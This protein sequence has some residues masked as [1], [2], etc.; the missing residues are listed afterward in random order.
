MMRELCAQYPGYEFS[1]HK[2]YGT[3][4]HIDLLRLHGPCEAHRRTFQP[5]ADMLK[6]AT[7]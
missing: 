3:K 4:E 2:G 7:R 6:A 5:V 1:K